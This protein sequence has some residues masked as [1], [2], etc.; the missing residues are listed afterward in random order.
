MNFTVYVQD[1]MGS[2][3]DL[4]AKVEKKSRNTLVREALEAYLNKRVSCEWPKEVLEFQGVD[5]PDF[6]SFRSELQPLSSEFVV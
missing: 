3:L 5:I 6:Q 2:K 4:L 1:E